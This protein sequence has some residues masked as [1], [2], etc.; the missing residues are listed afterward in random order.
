MVPLLIDLY[1]V[2]IHY[3]LLILIEIVHPLIIKNKIFKILNQI[4][5]KLRKE[6]KLILLNNPNNLV[7]W[8]KI[9]LK[10]S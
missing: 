8:L 5:I 10:K 7:Y 2:L 6:N 4:S 3:L 9:Y 1:Q